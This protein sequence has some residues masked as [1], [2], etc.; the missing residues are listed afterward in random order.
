MPNFLASLTGAV[1]FAK[2]P[3]VNTK[4]VMEIPVFA[5]IWQMN[6]VFV[7]KVAV[8]DVKAT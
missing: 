6:S 3:N 4:I 7:L 2:F 8:K 5:I 1:C